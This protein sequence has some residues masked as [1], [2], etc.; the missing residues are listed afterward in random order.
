MLKN[1]NVTAQGAQPVARGP[2]LGCGNE[3]SVPLSSPQAQGSVSID[4]TH[5]LIPN[6]APK[7][8]GTCGPT[9]A[10]TPPAPNPKSK[11][12]KGAK[13]MIKTRCV[14]RSTSY[15]MRLMYRHCNK[16]CRLP[17]LVNIYD[18]DYMAKSK[19]EFP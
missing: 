17:C 18:I 8:P 7:V 19:N 10:P 5:A 14:T 12:D 1:P 6:L 11:H 15:V 4:K 13:K 2:W 16:S 9:P 3:L